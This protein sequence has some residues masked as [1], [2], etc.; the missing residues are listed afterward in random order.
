MALHEFT[1]C[2][3][4]I[5][6][7]PTRHGQEQRFLQLAEDVGVLEAVETFALE[8]YYERDGEDSKL[9]PISVAHFIRRMPGSASNSAGQGLERREH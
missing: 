1:G 6:G 3:G 2:R 4:A 9:R 8:P 7:Y 5:L